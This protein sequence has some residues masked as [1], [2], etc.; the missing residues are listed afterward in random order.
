[1]QGE[2]E[3]RSKAEARLMKGLTGEREQK[4]LQ[5]SG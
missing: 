1:M 4:F 2:G 5:H 3:L